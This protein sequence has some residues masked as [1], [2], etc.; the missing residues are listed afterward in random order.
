M[1]DSIPEVFIIESLRFDDE[2]EE[3]YEGQI[4][5]NILKLNNKQSKYYYIRTKKELRAV[6]VKFRD[7]NY[8]YL[9]LS[10]HANKQE[11]ATTLDLI[12]FDELSTILRPYLRER[13]LFVSACEMVNINL[14]SL[15]LPGSGCFSLMGPATKVAFSDAAIIWASLYHLMFN[16]ARDMMKR[17]FLILYSKALTTLFGVPLNFY[18][19]KS[20]TK[21]V[22]EEKIRRN[23]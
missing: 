13:R 5:S 19:Y 23:F 3:N 10:C 21:E 4:I 20:K 7:S 11:M 14:A 18:W 17:N 9:H 2:E 1:K 15:L 12:P 6:L 8:R 16:H 22:S